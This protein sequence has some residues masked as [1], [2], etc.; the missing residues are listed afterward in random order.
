MAILLSVVYS[1]C[2][3]YPSGMNPSTEDVIPMGQY[4]EI[5]ITTRHTYILLH[6]YESDV[7]RDSLPNR[8]PGRLA[9]VVVKGSVV[10]RGLE[11]CTLNPRYA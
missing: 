6:R 2:F 4:K 8:M 3:Q 9:P 11:S 5:C 10:L 1:M 7:I